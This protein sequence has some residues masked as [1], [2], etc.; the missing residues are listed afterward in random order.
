MGQRIA[1]KKNRWEKKQNRLSSNHNVTI[2]ATKSA[3]ISIY[4]TDLVNYRIEQNFGWGKLWQIASKIV[5]GE[6]NYGKFKHS[7]YLKPAQ[8]LLSDI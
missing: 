3:N 1:G 8:Y 4:V 5:F 7:L 6:I 2:G